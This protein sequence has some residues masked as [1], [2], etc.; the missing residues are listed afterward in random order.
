MHLATEDLVLRMRDA[1]R[2][3]PNLQAGPITAEVNEW[4]SHAVALVEAC[5]DLADTITI[6]T[7]GQFLNSVNRALNAQ[8]IEI[9]LRSTLARAELVMPNAAPPGTTLSVG[10][11]FSNLAAIGDVL[12]TATKDVLIVDPYVD[13]MVL[14][15]F[16]GFLHEY[17]QLRLLG[18]AGKKQPSLLP[19]V[20]AWQAEHGVARPI[21]ARLSAKG[22]LHNRDIIVDSA[23]VWT[24]GQSLKDVAVRSPDTLE[25]MQPHLATAE[26]QHYEAIWAAASPL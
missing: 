8:Q 16:G 2:R 11:A 26:I 3:M 20:E 25:A 23:K 10:Q 18:D 5:G 9:V 1:V 6:K 7:A 14:A 4:V 24:V 13:G 17:V 12:A 19:A 22:A 15:R 21:E